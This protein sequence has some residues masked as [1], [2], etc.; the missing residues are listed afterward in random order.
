MPNERNGEDNTSTILFIDKNSNSLLHLAKINKI[1]IS[2]SL[3]PVESVLWIC[4]WIILWKT[5]TLNLKFRLFCFV[6]HRESPLI[7]RINF[8][9][10]KQ[11]IPERWT[12]LCFLNRPYILFILSFLYSI[13]LF[14]FKSS[15]ITV[16]SAFTVDRKCI[17]LLTI[18]DSWKYICT[19]TESRG[20][21]SC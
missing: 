13:E 8:K 18:W 14:A 20:K 2:I 9:I 4:S 16:T 5:Y 19:V 7:L 15:L 3:C 12:D 1:T 10:L 17:L 11:N 21:F 6:I